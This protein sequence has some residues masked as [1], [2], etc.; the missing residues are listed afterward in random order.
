VF[1]NPGSVQTRWGAYC[2]PP[3]PLP[4]LRRRGRVIDK[5]RGNGRRGKEG[6]E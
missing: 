2:V 3:N 1:W 6:V 5:G 4:G